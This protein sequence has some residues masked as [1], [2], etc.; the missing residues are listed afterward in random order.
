MTMYKL[1]TNSQTGILQ[2]AIFKQSPHH[3]QRPPDA[4]VDMI[5]V[6]GISLPPGKFGGDAIEQFFC[7]DLDM[8]SHPYFDQIKS[9]RVSSHLLIKRTGDLVQ[10]VPFHKRA[11][12]AGE[13]S[14]AG[15]TKCNDFSIGI[16]LE[17]TDDQPYEESQYQS[18]AAVIRSLMRV[19]PKITPERVV[20]HSDIAPGRKTDPGLA[21]DWDYLRGML[22]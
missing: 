15:K 16:E 21:F 4:E 18:L 8:T 9:L 19:F 17:G 5:V 13:S 12:H 10:F 14:F 6:H 2:S 7:G 11:W 20:G 22:G 3:D 1:I